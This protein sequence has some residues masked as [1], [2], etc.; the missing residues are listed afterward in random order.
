ML[1]TPFS[2]SASA[3]ARFSYYLCVF[4]FFSSRRRH[5]RLQGDRSSD[6]CSSDLL[7]T[8]S[9]TRLDGRVLDGVASLVGEFAEVHLEAVRRLGEHS[10]VRPGAEDALLARGDHDGADFRVLEPEPLDRVG[11]LDVH[12]EVVRVEL[13]LVARPEPAV[14]LH[15]HGERGDGPVEAE[16]PVLVPR[17]LGPEIDANGFAVSH[18][19]VSPGRPGYPRMTQSAWARFVPRFSQPCGVPPSS[20]ALSPASSRWRSPV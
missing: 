11:E 18:C 9:R 3:T 8:P 7:A 6:V 20:S 14:L 10:D 13:E 16:L 17:R 5:T 15:V 19:P 4:F 1:A 12:A 2:R